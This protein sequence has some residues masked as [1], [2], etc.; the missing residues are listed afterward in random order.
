M[1]LNSM[2]GAKIAVVDDE[3]ANVELLQRL[4]EME[5]YTGVS[6]YTDPREF[7]DSCRIL[8]PDIVLLDLMMPDLNGFEVLERLRGSLDDFDY[9]PVMIITSDDD[10]DTKRQALSSGARDFLA[11]PV[12]PVEVRLRVRNLLQTRFLQLELQRHAEQLEDRVRTRT[13]ELEEARLEILERLA[14]AAEYRDDATGEHTRRVGRESA[15]LAEALGLSSGQ[16]EDIRRAAPLHDV[17]KIALPDTI[18]LKRGSLAEDETTLMREHTTVG[19]S[20]LSGSRFPMMRIAE[21]I[22]L[23][24]H[25]CWDGTGYPDGLKGEQIPLAARIVAVIDVFDSLTHARVYKRAWTTEEALDE[26]ESLA[27][28]KFDPAVAEAFLRMHGRVPAGT[29]TDTTHLDEAGHE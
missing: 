21:E 9:R 3:T 18:L 6:G 11:K 4:L 24:H 17:G 1:D 26:I 10:R 25:E 28:T 23:H 13:A 15:A 20:I 27:G 14:L 22:A 29:A 5:G 19:A 7:L 8:P 12:S 2:Y 16:V